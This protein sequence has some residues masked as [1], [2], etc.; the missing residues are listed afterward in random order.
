VAATGSTV[1][2]GVSAVSCTPLNQAG[3]LLT[4]AIT[5]SSRLAPATDPA[6]GPTFT[7]NTNA[8]ATAGTI[9]NYA[10]VNP[11]GSNT[12]IVNPVGCTASYCWQAST[13][14]SATASASLS[15]TKSCPQNAVVNVAMT[16][17]LTFTNVGTGTLSSGAA[18]QLLDA[19]PSGVTYVAK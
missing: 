8:P 7:V 12:G 13:V 11:T 9:T 10:A 5:L 2:T 6:T 14:I 17:T 16:C 1:G 3:A 15:L 18:V 4:C 19:L